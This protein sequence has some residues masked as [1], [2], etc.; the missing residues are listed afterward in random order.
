MSETNA[1]A[2][3]TTAAPPRSTSRT[4]L[5]FARFTDADAMGDILWQRLSSWFAG[6]DDR[7]T[8]AIEHSRYKTYLKVQ[9]RPRSSLSVCYRFGLTGCGARSREVL[10]YVK[11][12]L[13]GRS[14]SEWEKLAPLRDVDR[15]GSPPV[16]HLPELDAIAWRFPHD[17]A[18]AHLRE[19]IEPGRVRAHVP[20]RLLPHGVPGPDRT[21]VSS[22]V[23]HYRPETRCTTRYDL[24]WNE[25][26]APRELTIYGKTFNGDEGRAIY[27]RMRHLWEISRQNADHL[28]VPQPLAYT[29]AVH[30]IW[31]HAVPGAP[32]LRVVDATNYVHYLDAVAKGLATIHTSG[33]SGSIAITPD[34]HLAESC[35]KSLKLSEAFPGLVRPLQALIRHLETEMPAAHTSRTLIHGDLQMH[36]L[37]ANG[38][39][40]AFLDFDECADGDPAQDLANVVVNLHFDGVPP[41]LVDAMSSVLLASYRRAIDG[42]VPA[43]RLDWYARVQF[44]NKA[45][46]AY[47]RHAP[48]VEAEVGHIVELAARATPFFPGKRS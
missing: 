16:I 12:Y 2:S 33:L 19:V 17:P 8:C 34:D 45:Y 36:Q 47:L 7:P 38:G 26:G 18:L 3:I 46:R 29:D 11:A 39:H 41:T 6:Q 10:V 25:A 48:G 44:L 9:S 42:E 27:D 31:Q 40:V 32:L 15:H 4:S 30:T 14:W 20:W 5:P 35:K 1:A 13:G 21:A 37:L 28:R 24:R 43:H 22:S 23:A